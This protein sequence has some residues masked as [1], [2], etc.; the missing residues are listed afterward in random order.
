M[1]QLALEAVMTIRELK[2][3]L[4]ACLKDYPGCTYTQSVNP[5][6]QCGCPFCTGQ[7]T[8]INAQKFVDKYF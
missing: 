8:L 3:A 5:D 4:E 6:T 2:D 7:R 1:K